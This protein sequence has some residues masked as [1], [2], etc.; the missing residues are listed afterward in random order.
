M[1]MTKEDKKLYYAKNR[2]KLAKQHRSY[3]LKRL[4]G[5]SIDLYDAF[6]DYQGGRCAICGVHQD[7]LARNLDVDHDHKTGKMRGL[8]CNRCN[9]LLGYS[10]DSVSVLEKAILYITERSEA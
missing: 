6:F 2:T 9:L 3:A 7:E 10:N 1:M 8:L 5:V 4:Y